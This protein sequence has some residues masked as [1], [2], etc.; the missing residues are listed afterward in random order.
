MD[1]KINENIEELNNQASEESV[2][3]QE[4][5]LT[6]AP[7]E[8]LSEPGDDGLETAAG[9]AAEPENEEPE[10]EEPEASGSEPE[11]NEPEDEEPEDEEPEPAEEPEANE[12]EDGETEPAAE[13][14][15]GEPEAGGS[16]TAAEPAADEAEGAEEVSSEPE[17]AAEPE[18]GRTEKTSE[19]EN[20]ATEL[21]SE[22][23]DFDADDFDEEDEEPLKSGFAGFGQIFRNLFARRSD[24]NEEDDFSDAS[25]SDTESSK[26]RKK[27]VKERKIRLHT[28]EEN[29]AAKQRFLNIPAKA[30]SYLIVIGGVLLAIFLLVMITTHW[31][32]HSYRVLISRTQEDTVSSEYC[33]VEDDILRY[34]VDG[35]SLLDRNGEVIWD[36]SYTMS[37]PRVAIRGRTIAIY[38]SAGSD[39]VICDR[40]GQ[41]GS[42]SA[43]LP[44][45]K[46]EVSEDG[47]VAAIEEDSSNA[48]I[49]YYSVDGTQ[50]AEIRTSIDDPGYPLDLALSP[51]GELIAVSY[52]TVSGGSESSS[53]HIYSFGS[54]GQ[55]QMDNQIGQF[56]YSGRVIPELDYISSTRLVAFSDSGF[57]IINGAKVPEEDVSVQV[58]DQIQSVFCDDSHIGLITTS[59]SGHTLCVY[60]TSGRQT[61]SKSFD[62]SYETMDYDDEEVTLYNDN[63]F[64]V[65]NLNGVCKFDGSYTG[66]IVDIFAVGKHRYGV[67]KEASMEIIQLS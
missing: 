5:S 35:A 1:E 32:Y 56:D 31:K 29:E 14:E 6:E 22:P 4:A 48:Y 53:V 34:G 38:D 13:P 66:S 67:V 10:Y 19:S 7:S 15:D 61:L 18:D 42:A 26:K 23:E 52:L 60:T 63:E 28:P 46:A 65:Y 45:I 3:E 49:E 58:S 8:P 9:P 55:N 39:I 36:V 51:D 50:I 54:A 43:S 20:G 2:A 40:T 59:G 24:E 12:P 41:I 62:Y 33:D 27:P 17:P 11:D 30:I 47:N 16:E 25:G 64:C 44:I 57:T 37:E 21:T